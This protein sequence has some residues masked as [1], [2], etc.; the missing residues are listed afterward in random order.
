VSINGAFATPFAVTRAGQVTVEITALSPDNTVTVGL[1][2]GTWN[3]SACQAVISNDSAKLSSAVIGTATAAGTLC[4]RV[5]DV[6]QLAAPT[7]YEVKV[8]HY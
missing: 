4:V 7:D 3:G 1:T 8:D 6:G 5:Y 2:L